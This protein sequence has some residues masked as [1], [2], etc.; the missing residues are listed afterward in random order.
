MGTAEEVCGGWVI[1]LVKALPGQKPSEVN[2]PNIKCYARSYAKTKE[3]IQLRWHYV[4]NENKHHIK[5][6]HERY[7]TF[8]YSSLLL[9][10]FGIFVCACAFKNIQ[11]L[12]HYNFIAGH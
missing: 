1:Y 12:C 7:T 11:H 6:G 5:T 8:N 4:Y 3:R 2:V 10:M 9:N